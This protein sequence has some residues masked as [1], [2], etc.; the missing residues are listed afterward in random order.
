[1]T[2]YRWPSLL[3]QMAFCWPCHITKVHY[4]VCGACE[5][6]EHVSG[7]RPLPMTALTYSVDWVCCCHLL[8]T[9]HCCLCPKATPN[10]CLVSGPVDIQIG[11]WAGGNCHYY[12]Y[13]IQWWNAYKFSVFQACYCIS[14]YLWECR[15]IV[16]TD[17]LT[18]SLRLTNNLTMSH[19]NI[20]VAHID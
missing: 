17:I 11:M 13:A 7:A 9:K 4:S 14:S 2:I 5:W 1:M 19:P 20:R 3:S 10:H 18:S 8:K 12:H 6:H 15:C 16:A